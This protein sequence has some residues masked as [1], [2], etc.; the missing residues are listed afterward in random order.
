[1]VNRT[2]SAY[3]LIANYFSTLEE[4]EKSKL[5]FEILLKTKL[6]NI[7]EVPWMD[8]REESYSLW[9]QNNVHVRDPHVKQR[10]PDSSATPDT[11]VLSLY[12]LLYTNHKP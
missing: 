7:C 12:R 3:R 4:K 10:D 1:M 5:A 6:P 8:F 9:K 11:Q 2:K